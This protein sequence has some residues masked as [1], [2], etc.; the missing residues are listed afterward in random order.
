MRPGILHRS[1]KAPAA[2]IITACIAFLCCTRPPAAA[3]SSELLI[4][5]AADL[6]RAAPALA[7][8]FEKQTGVPVKFTFGATGLLARQI[9]DGAPFDAFLAADMQTLRDLYAARDEK[10]T[11]HVVT[12]PRPYA[13]GHL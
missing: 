9:R 2:S 11:A 12:E 10:A 7:C 8:E 1:W 6:Q 3:Q 4:A 5:A 13:C